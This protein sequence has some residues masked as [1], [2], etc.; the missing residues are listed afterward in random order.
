MDSDPNSSAHQFR[1]S[2]SWPLWNFL[3]LYPTTGT[4]STSLLMH[5]LH[6]L[7]FFPFNPLPLFVFPHLVDYCF[8]YSTP[9]TSYCTEVPRIQE[10]W[11]IIFLECQ[12]HGKYLVTTGSSYTSYTV[13]LKWFH[14]I[15][16][17]YYMFWWNFMFILLKTIW[18]KQQCWF[19]LFS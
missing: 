16:M 1:H 19:P 3:P 9:Y 11:V 14:H 6:L 15:Y 5:T 10:R 17:S 12:P 4:F 2:A 18:P 8:I 7:N 13:A